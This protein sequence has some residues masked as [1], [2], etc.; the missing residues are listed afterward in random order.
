MYVLQDRNIIEQFSVEGDPTDLDGLTNVIAATLEYKF[1]REEAE[2][3]T[4][5]KRTH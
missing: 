5:A 4:M 1:D 2:I 3:K